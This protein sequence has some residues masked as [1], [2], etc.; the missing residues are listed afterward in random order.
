MAFP[1]PKSVPAS[2]L[3]RLIYHA[4]AET[5]YGICSLQTS[6]KNSELET[7]PNIADDPYTWKKAL[8]IEHIRKVAQ[9]QDGNAVF[10][11]LKF[12]PEAFQ[13]IQSALSAV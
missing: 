8:L 5:L 12:K 3:A 13:F 9:T 11:A 10:L 1:R 7:W 2:A 6:R 4:D